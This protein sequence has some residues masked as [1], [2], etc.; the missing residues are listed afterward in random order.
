[1]FRP[2][3][4]LGLIVLR[5]LAR[6]FFGMHRLESLEPVKLGAPIDDALRLYGAPLEQQP[7][8]KIPGALSYTFSVE[9]F[10]ETVMTAIDGRVVH[11]TYWSEYPDPARDLRWMLDTYGEG[12]EWNLVE[13]GYWYWRKDGR[14]RLWCSAAPGIGVGTREYFEAQ[15]TNPTHLP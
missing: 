5:W 14:V 15:Q 8:D 3:A 6:T 13:A 4:K 9:L 10:H 7:S 11:I 12:V 2:F 1:M